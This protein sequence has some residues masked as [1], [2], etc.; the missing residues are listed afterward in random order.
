LLAC[1]P[2]ILEQ[3][4]HHDLVKPKTR[5]AVMVNYASVFEILAM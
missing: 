1:P 3:L 2:N 4:V 5:R